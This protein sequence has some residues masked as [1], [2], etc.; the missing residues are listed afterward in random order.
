LEA[1]CTL[2]CPQ[3]K[4]SFNCLSAIVMN[5]DVATPAML[6]GSFGLPFTHLLRFLFVEQGYLV[7]PR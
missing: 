1:T 6:N 2:W 7:I 3:Q 5:K 4:K